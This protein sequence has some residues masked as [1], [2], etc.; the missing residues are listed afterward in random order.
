M[1]RI[2]GFVRRDELG[3]PISFDPPGSVQTMALSINAK[4]D[5]TG[6]YLDANNR[7]HG[8]VRRP[9]GRSY[10]STCRTARDNGDRHQ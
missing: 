3:K 6:P 1:K 4:G 7:S 5:I 8:F 10:R 2:H 9:G